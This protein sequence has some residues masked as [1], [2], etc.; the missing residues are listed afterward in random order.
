MKKYFIFFFLFISV[1][2]FS[3]TS[4]FIDFLSIELKKE[5]KRIEE[6]PDAKK[7]EVVQFYQLKDSVITTEVY[8]EDPQAPRPIMR[9]DLKYLS[10]VVKKKDSYTG[11]TYTQRQELN[12]GDIQK[13]VKDINI[14]FT[15]KEDAVLVTNTDENGEVE[16]YKT[17]QFFLHL[18]QEKSNEYFA[19]EFV[20]IFN[21]EGYD[22]K[23]DIVRYSI[24]KGIWAD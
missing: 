12:L 24:E 19:D 21:K 11:K 9:A 18:N 22:K 8:V 17:D 6:N 13:I 14:L 23:D 16:T 4:K 3:Q 20:E 1:M 7:F 5:L 2:S 10:V 15:T